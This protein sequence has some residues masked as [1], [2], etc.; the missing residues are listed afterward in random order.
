MAFNPKPTRWT[1]N[2][3]LPIGHQDEAVIFLSTRTQ[4]GLGQITSKFTFKGGARDNT[5]DKKHGSQPG[6]WLLAQR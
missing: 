6:Q 2:G 5:G 3:S 1:L 4:Q